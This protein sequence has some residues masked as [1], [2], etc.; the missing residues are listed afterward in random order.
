M[1]KQSSWSALKIGA[2]VGGA[3][4]VTGGLIYTVAI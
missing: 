2:L 4:L 1:S 3:V